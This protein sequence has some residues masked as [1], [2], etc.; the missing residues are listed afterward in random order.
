MEAPDASLIL[1]GKLQETDMGKIRSWLACRARAPGNL[2]GASQS[3]CMYA[4]A[5]VQVVGMYAGAA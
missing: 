4:R 1:L 2:H 3:A 5:W